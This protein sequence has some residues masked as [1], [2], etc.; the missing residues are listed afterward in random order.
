MHLHQRVP[1]LLF[2]QMIVAA[3]IT[4]QGC[5]VGPA[6]PAG[7][8]PIVPQE[9]TM[10][11]RPDPKNPQ[12]SRPPVPETVGA[13]SAPFKL[14]KGTTTISF[15]IHAPTGPALLRSDGQAKRMLLR[16][17]N[18]TSELAAPSFGVYLNLP[19]GD[20]PQKRRD[21]YA[22]T[23]ST[24]GLVESSR[25]GEKHPGDGLNFVQ[26]VT[27][28]F[29]RLTATKDWDGKTLR[30]SFVPMRWKDYPLDVTVG[31]VSLVIE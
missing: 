31:R 13:T 28:L 23:L 24:F 11:S 6:R 8:G 9:S 27:E 30:V 20:D 1:A 26:D 2:T 17:E 5:A 29:V 14:S 16:V 25:T 10:E 12:K 7:A 15:E 19:P 3:G 4:F 18:L 21:L 22:L